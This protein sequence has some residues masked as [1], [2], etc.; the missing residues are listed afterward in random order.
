[1]AARRHVDVR[2]DSLGLRRLLEEVG[3]SEIS[4]DNYRNYHHWLDPASERDL[5]DMIADASFACVAGSKELERLPVGCVASDIE[6]LE[7]VSEVLTSYAN[8]RLA[9]LG[10]AAPSGDL[11]TF[12]DLDSALDSFAE[13]ISKYQAFLRGVGRTMEIGDNTDWNAVFSVPWFT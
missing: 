8:G 1:M 13:V 5:S 10:K 7:T 2:A 3:K 4:R 9:H 11:P 12:G 6:K